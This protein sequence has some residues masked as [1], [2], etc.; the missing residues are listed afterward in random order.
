ML[1]SIINN[2]VYGYVPV[3]KATL[4]IMRHAKSDWTSGAGT[5]FERP[6]ARRGLKDAPRMGKWLF[7][8]TGTPDCIVS[9]PARR[10]EVTARLV[11]TEL[12]FA[13][14]KVIWDD[15]IYDGDLTDLLDVIR[16]HQ[17]KKSL[18]L[19]GHNPGLE[20]LLHYLSITQPDS[21]QDGKILPTAAIAVLKSTGKKLVATPDSAKIK[22]I[23]RPRELG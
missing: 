9:S 13:E 14:K 19:I 18:L 1:H 8:Q 20:F 22:L 2:N 23:Q 17:S 15:R 10:A 5:D 11:L 12:N 21:N 16:D 3:S 7:K 6:L 4:I